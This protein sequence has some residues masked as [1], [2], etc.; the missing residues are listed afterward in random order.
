MASSLPNVRLGTLCGELPPPANS[1]PIAIPPEP[2]RTRVAAR[3]G[4][5]T[6]QASPLT[7]TSPA[8]YSWF[9]LTC[10]IAL[11]TT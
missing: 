3:S 7:R 4:S 6:H 8:L 5:P 11:A 1:A 10:A 9:P 2:W